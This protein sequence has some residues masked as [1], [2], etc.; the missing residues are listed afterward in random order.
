MKRALLALFAVVA[1]VTACVKTV[2]VTGITFDRQE[3]TVEV[4]GTITIR[5]IVNPA[6]AENPTLNWS[7]SDASVATVD[8]GK[9]TGVKPGKATITATSSDG[10]NV[11]ATC[12]VTVTE[13]A[14]PVTAVQ[15]SETGSI[16]LSADETLQLSAVVTPSNATYSAVEWASD[17]P[18]V[19]TVDANGLVTALGKGTANITA[20]IG[21]VTSE[22]LV[23]TVNVPMPMFAKFK[24]IQLREGTEL[25]G[26]TKIWVHYGTEDDYANRVEMMYSDAEVTSSNEAVIHVEKP[27]KF[28][29]PND[30]TK[31][32]DPTIEDFAIDAKA[33]S[34]GEATITITDI[35]GAKLEIPVVVTAKPEITHDWL[36]GKVLCATTNLYNESTGLGWGSDHCDITLGEGYAPGTQCVHFVNYHGV[37]GT[38]GTSHLIA[39]CKFF[40]VD[41]TNIPNPALYI[42]AYISDTTKV[43]LNAEMCQIELT[44]SG[45]ED[46]QEINWTCGRVFKNWWP[47]LDQEEN[48][49]IK[50][51]YDLRNGWNTIILPLEGYAQYN[52]SDKYY[53]NSDGVWNAFNPKMVCFFRWYSNPYNPAF[54]FDNTDFECAIDQLRIVDWTEYASVEEKNRDLWM[55]SGTANNCADYEFKE[56]LDGHEGVF[57]GKDEFMGV[58]AISNYW[59][60]DWSKTGRWGAREWSLPPNL[61]T[62]ELKLVFDL[63]VDDPEFFSSQDMRIEICTGSTM[64]DSDN[65]SWSFVPGEL[66][67]KKGWNTFN[68]DL[69]NS[70]TKGNLNPRSLY[71]FRIV[72]TNSDGVT[73]SRHSYYIDDVRIVK[74]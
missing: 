35:N 37:S 38:T 42:R 18:S 26:V 11:K 8:N 48:G 5:A 62:D 23:V 19:A 14:I 12:E 24:A 58:M 9:V 52:D 63:W 56:S 13:K 49:N 61:T 65:F 43:S 27:I 36:P 16:I 51:L 46:G 21:G 64:Y 40:P 59:L 4:G 20:T 60:R 44:S 67:L 32:M 10:S 41:I 22:A 29:D 31:P 3:A 50:K 39:R 74:K 53:P 7:S 45:N 69:Q 34:A 47:K 68:L 57:G 33:I 6:D 30:P 17:D 2:K 66:N 72:W 55:E 70:K 25:T 71:T 15:L 1:L 54:T 28:P 73:P